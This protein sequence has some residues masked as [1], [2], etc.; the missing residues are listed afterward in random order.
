MPPAGG[1][2]LDTFT[3]PREFVDNPRYSRD[4]H[5]TLARLGVTAIDA[6]IAGVVAG[7]NKL[8]HCFTLQCCCGH[9]VRT[10]EQDPHTLQPLRPG[11]AGLVTYRI[12]YV[13]VCLEDSLRGQALRRTLAQ[14]PAIDPAYIQFGSA[15]WFWDQWPN[16][17]VLQVEPTAH[18]LKDQAVLE[19][20][21]AYRTQEARDSFFGE[22]KALLASGA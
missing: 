3:E 14:I 1:E 17:Y 18:M 2:T 15:D 7:L 20:A 22:L 13:A 9:F 12:A 21:E 10:A 11:H 5:D 16:S 4:R 8:S 19:A 6:P